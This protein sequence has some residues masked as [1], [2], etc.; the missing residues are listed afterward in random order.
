MGGNNLYF[1][2]V[3]QFILVL[4][5]ALYL[6]VAENQRS[7][8]KYPRR[9]KSGALFFETLGFFKTSTAGTFY[10]SAFRCSPLFAL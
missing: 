3:G 5:G 7:E 9:K 10:G 6:L 8:E 1:S 4:R 2:W